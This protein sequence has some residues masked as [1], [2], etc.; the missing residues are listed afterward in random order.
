[1]HAEATYKLIW[2]GFP[3]L[4]VESRHFHPFGIEVCSNENTEDFEF[5]F[6]SV[7]NGFAKIFG[8]QVFINDSREFLDTI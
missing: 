7:R 3:V 8:Q 4:V 1:M 6:N 5:L 2:Q